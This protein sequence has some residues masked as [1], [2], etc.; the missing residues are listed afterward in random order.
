MET[1]A[2]DNQQLSMVEDERFRELNYHLEEVSKTSP[3]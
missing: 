1:I 2:L 3:P